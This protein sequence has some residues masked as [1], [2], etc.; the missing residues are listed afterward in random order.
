MTITSFC[1]NCKKV[2]KHFM[3]NEEV[4]PK[5]IKCKECGEGKELTK[6]Y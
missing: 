1:K 4:T 5:L 6:D 2:T 3:H